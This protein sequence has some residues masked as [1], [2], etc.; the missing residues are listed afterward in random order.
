MARYGEG[1]KRWIV[2]ERPDGTNVHN[3]HW[4]ETNCL[5]WSRNFFNNLL[6]DLP[7]LTGESN[8]FIATTKVSSVDGEAYVNIRKGKIIP[9]YEISLTLAWQGEAKDSDG[10]SLLKVDGTVEIP[11]ISDENAGEDPEL[12]VTV[13]DEGPIG[14]TLKDAMLSKGKPLILDKIRVWVQSMAKGGPVKDELET[15]KP[16]PPQ[17]QNH[18]AAAASAAVAPSLASAATKK[19]GSAEKEAKKKK[20]E[21]FKSISMTERFNCRA[22]DLY[23]ILL[24]ENRWKGFTQSNAKISKEVGGE[25]SIFDGSVTGTN[26]ELQEAKLIVQKWRFGSW[27]DG[28]HSLVKLVL[29]EPEPGVTV[30]KLTHNDVP[31]EDR[32]GN[33]TVVENTERGWRDLIFQRIRAVFGFGI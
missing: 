30:V 22:R 13:K 29:E 16:T 15:K 23:E 12:R 11:Y 4:S 14:R 1:D 7:I 26:V 21:G 24:D 9:G 32:Y 20:K 27:P 28:V 19:E 8:L 5:D 3:W 33:A 17:Q 2:E 31:E 10:K 25:F 18:A 6:N